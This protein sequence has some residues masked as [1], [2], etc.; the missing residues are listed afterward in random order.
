MLAEDKENLTNY[1]DFNISMEPVYIYGRTYLSTMTHTQKVIV[2]L[3]AI[4]I[5]FKIVHNF[6]NAMTMHLAIS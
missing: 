1:S 4:D 6:D 2:T 5:S 3:Q